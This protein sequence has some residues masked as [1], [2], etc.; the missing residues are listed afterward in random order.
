[1]GTCPPVVI[2]RKHGCMSPVITRN[3]GACR[4]RHREHGCMFPDVIGKIFTSHISIVLISVLVHETT[5][6]QEKSCHFIFEY[7]SRISWS[8]FAIFFTSGHRNEHST[9]PCNL[10]T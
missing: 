5:L 9:I 1:M 10:L 2:G 6:C 4:R 3:T 7:N 8:I